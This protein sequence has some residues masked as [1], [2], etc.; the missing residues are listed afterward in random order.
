MNSVGS[1]V[2][3]ATVGSGVGPA[4]VGSGVGPAKVGEDEL[5]SS[6]TSAG[7]MVG[8]GTKVGI[9]SCVFIVGDSVGDSEGV[10][11]GSS[12]VHTPR[13]DPFL[14]HRPTALLQEWRQLPALPVSGL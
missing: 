11:D 4:K 8:T 12:V 2:G 14:K 7:S 5:V 13:D 9:S 10:F 3:P 6:I 1:R